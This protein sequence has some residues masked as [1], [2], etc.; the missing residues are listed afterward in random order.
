[1]Q[2]KKLN[3]K[4]KK[5]A[6]EVLKKSAS[7]GKGKMPSLSNPPLS[8]KS[9]NLTRTKEKDVNEALVRIQQKFVRYSVLV[10]IITI[11]F[12]LVYHSIFADG[13]LL[14]IGAELLQKGNSPI[15]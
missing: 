9:F 5:R 15:L 12:S 6:K 3:Q 14:E 8:N 4:K 10:I 13:G 11:A 7:K 2:N 1:M